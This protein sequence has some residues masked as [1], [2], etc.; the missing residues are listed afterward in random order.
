MNI[1]FIIGLIFLCLNVLR[2]ITGNYAI[3]ITNAHII[4]KIW[5][6]IESVSINIVLLILIINYYK[7]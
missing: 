4:V 5:N 6:L 1:L 7:S 3:F 2:F